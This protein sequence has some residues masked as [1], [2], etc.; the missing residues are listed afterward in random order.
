MTAAT[1][2]AVRGRRR[3]APIAGLLHLPTIHAGRPAALE[4]WAASTVDGLWSVERDETPGTPWSALDRPT[5]HELAFGS[6]PKF[7]A[8]AADTVAAMRFLRAMS[9]D[10]IDADGDRGRAG[11]VDD[12]EAAARPRRAALARAQVAV[13]DG[14]MLHRT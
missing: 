3:P 10:L 8:F 5:G 2:R 1:P 12:F 6:L 13:L 7:R 9:Q 4:Q 11:P 14:L